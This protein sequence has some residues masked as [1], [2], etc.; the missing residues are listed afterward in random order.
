MK[1][2]QIVKADGAEQIEFVEVRREQ[3][4]GKFRLKKGD[5]VYAEEWTAGIPPE[6]SLKADRELKICICTEWDRLR[7]PGEKSLKKRKTHIGA[8]RA[9]PVP[10]VETRKKACLEAQEKAEKNA[11]EGPCTEPQPCS[12]KEAA[13]N[14]PDFKAAFDLLRP[15]QKDMLCCPYC[16]VTHSLRTDVVK[17]RKGTKRTGGAGMAWCP[18]EEYDVEG[19]NGNRVRRRVSYKEFCNGDAS[20]SAKD[21]A[22]ERRNMHKS[23]FFQCKVQSKG[24]RRLVAICFLVVDAQSEFLVLIAVRC[25]LFRSLVASP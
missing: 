17:H 6:I 12:D 20:Q 7:Q 22:A 8:K 4:A 16:K 18:Y 15:K 13:M 3:N 9:A 24:R 10:V 21:K 25:R 5:F 14:D 1:I 11:A 19:E 23:N 2:A